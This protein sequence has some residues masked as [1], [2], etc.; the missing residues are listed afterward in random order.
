MSCGPT[1]CTVSTGCSFCQHH[2][3]IQDMGTYQISGGHPG[4][5]QTRN[6]EFFILTWSPL[7]SM[8]AFHAF[9]FEIHSYLVSAMRAR[10]SALRS[11]HSTAVLNSRDRASSMNEE[12]WAKDRTLMHTNSH[13]KLLTVLTIDP[14]TTTGLG[15]HALDDPHS[16]FPDP[17]AP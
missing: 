6:L 2:Y 14:H 13:T 12:Q 5:H 17:K 10:T 8:P 7:L 15:V 11:S 4:N 9:S 16:P 3:S 1:A